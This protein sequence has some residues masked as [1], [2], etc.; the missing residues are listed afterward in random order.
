M[1]K[2]VS[3]INLQE[4]VIG[5]RRIQRQIIMILL[6]GGKLDSRLIFNWIPGSSPTTSYIINFIGSFPVAL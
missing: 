5:V 3:G 6:E 2:R 4:I 1:L